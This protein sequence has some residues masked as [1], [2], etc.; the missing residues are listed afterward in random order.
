MRKDRKPKKPAGTG[1]ATLGK[2][3]TRPKPDKRKPTGGP[4]TAG[5]P[6]EKKDRDDGED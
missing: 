6:L 2:G 1:P 3:R 4:G 5:D